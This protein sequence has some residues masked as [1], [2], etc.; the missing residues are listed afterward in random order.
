[1]TGGHQQVEAGIDGILGP[2]TSS[3]VIGPFLSWPCSARRPGASIRRVS[4]G[5]GAFVL[6][7][8]GWSSIVNSAIVCALFA[9][10]NERYRCGCDFRYTWCISNY[11]CSV[12]RQMIGTRLRDLR[13]L[14]NLDQ[15]QVAEHLG[16]HRS[17]VSRVERGQT[18]VQ[19]EHVDALSRLYQVS[20]A[21]LL[22]LNH[23]MVQEERGKNATDNDRKA[24]INDYNSP[25]GLRDLASNEI[26]A[27]VLNIR[28]DEWKALSYLAQGWT[29]AQTATRDNWVLILYA[30][31]GAADQA[32]R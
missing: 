21:Y 18:W 6:F 10:Y 32:P 19:L 23:P 31:R 2:A 14:R 15:A 12:D 9:T 20:P 27:E 13:E 24:I 8:M 4:S 5:V 25:A 1:M 26:L 28:P 22:C 16:V 30:L 29:A 7:T 11:R 17:Q 3:R